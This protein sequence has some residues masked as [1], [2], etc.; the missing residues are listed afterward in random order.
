MYRTTSS[1]VQPATNITESNNVICL[2]IFVPV[3][4]GVESFKNSNLF[5]VTQNALAPRGPK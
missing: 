4:A 2:V 5:S 1:D 3:R